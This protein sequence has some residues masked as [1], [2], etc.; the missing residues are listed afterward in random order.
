MGLAVLM[1]LLALLPVMRQ[2]IAGT[3]DEADRRDVRMEKYKDINVK[4]ILKDQT[5]SVIAELA[6]AVCVLAA[7]WIY[8]YKGYYRLHP[9]SV[10]VTLGLLVLYRDHIVEA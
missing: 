8:F 6:A 1:T 2:I 7:C 10:V 4:K 3:R 9:I 5:Y